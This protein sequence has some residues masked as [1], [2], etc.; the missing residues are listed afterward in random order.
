MT[1]LMAHVAYPPD[2]SRPRGYSDEQLADAVATSRSWRGVLRA[3]GLA[4]TSSGAIRSVRRQ[5]ETLGLDHSHFRGQ[6]RW[7]DQQLVE[8]VRTARSWPEVMTLLGLADD[9]SRATLEGHALRLGLASEHLQEPQDDEVAESRSQVPD[10]S[11]LRRAGPMLAAAWFTLCGHDVSWPLEPC[12]YDLLVTAAGSH[13][14]VQVKTTTVRSGRSWMVWLS[15]SRKPRVTYDVN[16]IDSFFVIDGDFGFYRIPVK[17][18]AGLHSITLS[19]Y[20][21]YRVGQ[22][23]GFASPTAVG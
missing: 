21:D 18:V 1:Q 11:H 9:R 5:A 22:A 23:P 6:R 12:P 2:M 20:A 19:A 15:K 14:R 17:A 4:A 13:D 3:L 10:V 7:T 8:A 16:S